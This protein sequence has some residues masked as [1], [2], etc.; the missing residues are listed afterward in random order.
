MLYT[1][2]PSKFQ[3]YQNNTPRK[4]M[5]AVKSSLGCDVICN[6][7]LFNMST[8]KPVCNIKLDGKVLNEDQYTYTG[9]AWNDGEMP[10]MQAGAGDKENFIS[11][12]ALVKDGKPLTMYYNSGLAGTRG[13]TAIGFKA[14]G[15]FVMWCSSDSSEPK[16]MEQLRQIMIDAGCDSAMALDGGG[17]SSCITPDKTISTT[18]TITSY[19]CVWAEEEKKEDDGVFRI[20]L[21]A[22]HYINTA[23]KR[24][25]KSL[26]PN[27]TREWWLNDRICDKVEDKLNAYTGYELLRLDDTDGTDAIELADRV[28]AAEDFNADFFLSV[29]HN[30]G[31]NGGSGGG[32]M[33]FSYPASDAVS[34]KWRD[35]LYTELIAQTGLKGNRAS[36]KAIGNYYVLR[37][38]SMPSVLLELGFMDSKTDVPIILTEEYAEQCAQAIVNVLVEKGGLTKKKTASNVLYRVQVGAFSDKTNAEKLKAELISKGYSAYIVNRASLY[39]VQVGAFTLRENSNNLA[40]RLKALGYSVYNT[41]A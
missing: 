39:R 19:I 6:G 29:H 12:V 35:E 38:S 24:C 10:V 1:C 31:I 20:A 28:K 8:G 7:Y 25:L 32:I 21:A 15:T 13:R 27:E 22:G 17:S 37:E 9:Y 40:A 11:C 18:R 3:V 33:A 34:A 36:P 4:S 23:G 16:T 26:D 2:K 5:A 41:T 30:A 14:D